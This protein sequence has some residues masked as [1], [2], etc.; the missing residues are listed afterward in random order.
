MRY[1]WVT[2]TIIKNLQQIIKWS[3]KLT[4]T[5]NPDCVEGV[6]YSETCLKRTPLGPASIMFKID[7]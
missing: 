1:V 2:F 4:Y 7:R 5:V 3:L 6:Y